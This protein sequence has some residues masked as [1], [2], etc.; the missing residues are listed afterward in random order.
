MTKLSLEYIAGFFDGEGCV[1]IQRRSDGRSHYSVHA[2]I[3]QVDPQNLIKIQRQF[4]GSLREIKKKVQRSSWRLTLTGSKAE[5]FLKALV[6]YLQNKKK[7]AVLALKLRDKANP[8]GIALQEKEHL[9]RKEIDL[10]MRT[11]KRQNYSFTI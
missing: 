3:G 7:E 4:G 8:T 11:L 10:K 2:S 5:I 1:T 6:P 9:R